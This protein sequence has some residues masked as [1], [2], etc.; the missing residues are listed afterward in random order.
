MGNLRHPQTKNSIIDEAELKKYI[1]NLDNY[2]LPLDVALPIFDWYILFEEARYK[3]LVRELSMPEVAEEQKGIVFRADTIING[4]AF[5]QGQWLRHERSDAAV[6]RK[7][8]EWVS[9]KLKQQK[10]TVILYHLDS[11][12]LSNYSAHELETFYNSL[13]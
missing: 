4:Y 11:A 7:C 12:N 9:K 8:G 1:S 5:K 13:R 6:V 10:L 2:S 3:G